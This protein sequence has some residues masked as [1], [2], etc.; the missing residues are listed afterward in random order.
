M[1][2]LEWNNAI[3]K[4]F[5]NPEN[6]EKEVM[7]YFSEAII[8]EIGNTNFTRPDDG[9]IEDF[10]K[11]IKLG[12]LGVSNDNYINRIL[13]LEQKYLSGC[14]RIASI[15]FEYPPYLSYL[16][17]F[18]LPF[19]SGNA[20]EDFNMS[21]FH[22]YV[23]NF[24]ENRQ[25]TKNYDVIIKNNLNKIDSLWIKIN[26]WLIYERSCILGYLEE[27]NP[28]SNKKFVG[29]FEYHI[30]FRKEQEERLSMLF[31]KKEILPGEAINEEKM[32]AILVDNY[33]DLKLSITSKNKIADRNDYIGCKIIK[34]ALT[35]YNNWEGTNYTVES[36]RG[37]SRNRLVLCLDFNGIKP[38]VLKYVRIFSKNGIP[39]NLKLKK[40]NGIVLEESIFQINSFYSNPIENCF[41]DLNTDIQLVDSSVRNKYTWKAKNLLIFKK[42][43]HFD[44]VEIPRVEYCVGKT[45]IICNREYYDNNLKH[46]FEN[47]SN[48]KK[49][50]DNNSL[51]NLPHEFLSLTIETITNCPHPTIQELIPELEQKPKINFDKSFYIDGKLFKDKLPKVW[52]ENTEII[53]QV[54][55]KYEDGFEIPLIQ[56]PDDANGGNTIVNQFD[57]TNAH[58]ISGRLNQQFKLVCRNI[59]TH[60]FFQITDFKKISN[61]EIETILPKRDV[62]GQL[63]TSEENYFKGIEH[64]FSQK[65]I[66]ESKPFQKL[67]DKFFINQ[68]D[69]ENDRQNDSYNSEQLGNI[70]IHYISTKGELSKREFNDVVFLLLTNGQNTQKNIK[71]IAIRL[72]YLLQELGYV[73]YDSE[74]SNFYINKPHLLVVPSEKG[75]KFNLIGARDENMID[76]VTDYCKKN[77]FLTIEV[78]TNISNELLPQN[79][80]LHMKRCDHKLIQVL[81]DEIEI[82]FKKGNLFSQFALTSCFP[83]ISKW[84]SYINETLETEIQDTDGGYL[85]DVESLKFINKTNKFMRDL[86]F[87]KYTYINGYKTIYRLWHSETCYNIP[88]QQLGIYLYLYLYN[89]LRSK[90]YDQCLKL[91]SRVDCVNE[92]EEKDNSQSKTNI[93][94]Y[95]SER[96]LL[97]VPLTCKLPRYF[98]ISFQLLGDHLPLM[99]KID[100]EG[101]RYKESYNIYQNIPRHFITNILNNMLLKRDLLHPIHERQITI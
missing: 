83:D 27:I 46:W 86:A 76:A 37:F 1:T 30:L 91:T 21:N 57:F 62:I 22:G 63:T 90:N 84:K 8:E 75:T 33:Q 54:I 61:S 18:I 36:S 26:H 15:Q 72:S 43:S 49:L 50:Y 89:E 94:I 77:P 87:I 2:Y 78:Q 82:I 101:V 31:D 28:S 70:L 64:F 69:N 58:K 97:A 5:F 99:K 20:N 44:W 95:D 42:I 32:R 55:A 12:V 41:V 24:F 74:K 100:L 19:T 23:K 67:L 59:S 40:Q 11:A 51:T 66:E 80:Y 53:D 65:K 45:L 3:V 71:K 7:L 39:E 25:L 73:E 88:D 17:V 48:N 38:I 79:I 81:V 9:Y 85:F 96:R 4:H 60:R 6:E 52:L 14:R 98:S 13:M 35:F 34:R 47:I 92:L 29:K 16:L 56:S 68:S 93:L 10:Y